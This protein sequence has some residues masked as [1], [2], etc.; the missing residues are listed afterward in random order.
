MYTL[1]RAVRAALVLAAA[2]IVPVMIGTAPAFAA[3]WQIIAS[4]NSSGNDALGAVTSFSPSNVWAVGQGSTKALV[5][6]WDGSTW[7]IVSTP[8]VAGTS[9]LNGV[10][11]AAGDVWAVGSV[12]DGST[13]NPLVERWN[14]SAWSLVSA[15]SVPPSPTRP[16]SG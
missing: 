3:S 5:E 6:H 2:I 1:T 8:T 7:S 14:D 11:G 9:V 16:G 15:P 12:F 4:P 10:A 13:W